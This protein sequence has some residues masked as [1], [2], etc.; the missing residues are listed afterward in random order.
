MPSSAWVESLNTLTPSLLKEAVTANAIAI[1]ESS[2]MLTNAQKQATSG[3]DKEAA[4]KIRA[5]LPHIAAAGLNPYLAVVTTA[6]ELVSTVG[7]SDTYAKQLP[8]AIQTFLPDE[9]Q[10]RI[11]SFL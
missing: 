1:M 3:K 7:L 9:Q 6:E 4:D 2:S 10:T 5:Q 11:V 8:V